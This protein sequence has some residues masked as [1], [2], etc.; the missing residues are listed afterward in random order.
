M[1][2][3]HSADVHGSWCV[4]T[5]NGI[6]LYQ[7]SSLKRKNSEDLDNAIL[8]IEVEASWRQVG[9]FCYIHDTIYWAE[10]AKGSRNYKQSG[11]KHSSHEVD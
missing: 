2:H 8:M 10:E 1:R 5:Q 11:I 3:H 7:V 9:S 4:K 6:E